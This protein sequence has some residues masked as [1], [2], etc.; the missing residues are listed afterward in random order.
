MSEGERDDGGG[1]GVTPIG[2]PAGPKKELQHLRRER[3][4]TIFPK[5]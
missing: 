1:G 5:F 3:F 4:K 2:L